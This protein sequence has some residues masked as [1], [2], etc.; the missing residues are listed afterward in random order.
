[1]CKHI[2]PV[3]PMPPKK[4]QE[5][6]AMTLRDY[7]S[8]AEKNL[9]E[10]RQRPGDG[11]KGKLRYKSEKR[12]Y[13]W[14]HKYTDCVEDPEANAL[15]ENLNRLV[16]PG[17]TGT[18]RSVAEDANEGV[19][20]E[21]SNDEKKKWEWNKKRMMVKRLQKKKTNTMKRRRRVRRK[22]ATQLARR[23]RRKGRRR[24]FRKALAIRLKH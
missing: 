3:L 22:R 18:E 23:L 15:L 20:D 2:S 11:F 12:M 24:Q 5:E 10:L 7:T 6:M 21:D 1:M 16:D 14:M 19:V 8:W 17:P 4:T 9:S 13:S